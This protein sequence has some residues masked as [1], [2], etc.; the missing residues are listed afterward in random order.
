MSKMRI[1]IADTEKK[2]VSALET[3]FLYELRDDVDLEVITD[4]EYFS[5]FFAKPQTADI[6]VC[7]EELFT[8]DI[9]KHGIKKMFLLCEQAGTGSTEDLSVEL[10]LKYSSPQ[11]VQTLPRA[12]SGCCI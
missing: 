3:K 4:A 9:K 2:V 1:I 11:A 8:E 7:G 5:V 6:L 10:V 12:I